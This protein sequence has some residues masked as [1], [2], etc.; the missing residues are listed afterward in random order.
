MRKLVI[1][2]VLAGAGFAAAVP[3][4]AAEKNISASARNRPPGNL[5]SMLSL[6][7]RSIELQID[8]LSDRDLIGREE[9]QDLRREA[10]RLEHRPYRS[11][12]REAADVDL[13]VQRLQDHLRLATSDASLGAYASR[14]RDLG[15]F[16]DGDRYGRERESFTNRDSYKRADPRGDPFAIWKERDDRD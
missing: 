3:A 5:A 1:S 8:I 9:A 12:A 11:S 16:D 15:R 6:R 2:I 14:R 4:A 13:A 10:R 7:L